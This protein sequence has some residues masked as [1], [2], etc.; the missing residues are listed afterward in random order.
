MADFQRLR[1]DALPQE[2]WGN[3]QGLSNCLIQMNEKMSPAAGGAGGSKSVQ[4]FTL[5][6]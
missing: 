6:R 1:A 4:S 3:L 5:E 2:V